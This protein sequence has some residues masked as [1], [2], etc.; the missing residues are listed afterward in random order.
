MF[1]WS[2]HE[3]AEPLSLLAPIAPIRRREIPHRMSFKRPAPSHSP[4]RL[5]ARRAASLSM[6]TPNYITASTP[7]TH[8]AATYR[9]VPPLNPLPTLVPTTTRVLPD[10]PAVLNAPHACQAGRHDYADGSA[11]AAVLAA[12]PAAAAAVPNAIACRFATN[13]FRKNL[14]LSL[15]CNGASAVWFCTG[16]CP[17]VALA[18]VKPPKRVA[19]HRN[20][21]VVCATCKL[22]MACG[23]ST[24]GALHLPELTVVARPTPI[25]PT[26]THVPLLL[27]SIADS[28]PHT[29]IVG[30]TAKPTWQHAATASSVFP[31]YFD[32]KTTFQ[33]SLI[34]FDRGSG[35]SSL[36][37]AQLTLPVQFDV[38]SFAP[39]VN[40]AHSH[41]VVVLV[42][43]SSHLGL[44]KGAAAQPDRARICAVFTNAAVAALNASGT[45][46]PGPLRIHTITTAHL[47]TSGTPL[48]LSALGSAAVIAKWSQ[49]GLV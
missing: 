19:S 43:L 32:M 45:L 7:S 8:G 46:A 16:C 25:R 28:A 14:A 33:Q 31:P 49:P 30:T 12:G 47:I 3:S 37:S 41:H 35:W 40:S 24:C 15:I 36:I 39:S 18:L 2:E 34:L 42:R 10:V 21:E 6:T 4:R 48:L 23:C 1:A 5:G 29:A 20:K 44:A 17:T 22:A 13:T 26:A 9:I 27:V 38:C 11:V